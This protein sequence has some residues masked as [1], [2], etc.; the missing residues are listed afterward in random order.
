MSEYL[1]PLHGA[2]LKN[3]LLVDQSAF[4]NFALYIINLVIGRFPLLLLSK[5]KKPRMNNDK[6]VLM[7]VLYDHLIFTNTLL[8]L[9]QTRIWK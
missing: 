4:S 2:K 1:C 6:S 8:F 7:F 9:G 5:K 3:A